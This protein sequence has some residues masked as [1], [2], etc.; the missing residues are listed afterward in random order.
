MRGKLQFIVVEVGDK[1]LDWPKNL[2]V[3]IKGDEIR[4]DGL[5]YRVTRRHYSF[6]G[7][8]VNQWELRIYTKRHERQAAHETA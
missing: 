2:P 8:N 5:Y 3:P 4:W 1:A 7:D 6:Y